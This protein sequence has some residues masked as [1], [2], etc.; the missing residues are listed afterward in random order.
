MNLVD[1]QQARRML[2]RMVGYTDQSA[3]MGKGEERLKCRKGAVCSSYVSSA[4]ERMRSM[5]LFRKNT[6]VWTET[7]L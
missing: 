1:A 7:S 4:T 5:L 6:G 3:F 2:D